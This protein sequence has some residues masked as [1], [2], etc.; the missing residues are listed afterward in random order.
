MADR[1]LELERLHR[2]ARIRRT[3]SL[4][5]HWLARYVVPPRA[6]AI[7]PLP[8]VVPGEVAI[9][10]GGH[11][12]ALIR[13]AGKTVALDPML[14]RWIGGVHRAV[15][16]GLT[17]GHLRDVDV[18]LVSHGHAD[19]LHPA[20]LAHVPASATV[21]GPP[22]TGPRLG[23]RFARL[24]ELAGGRGVAVDGVRVDAV[25]VPHGAGALGPT[26]AFVIAGDGPRVFACA[27]GA[28]GPCYAEVGAALAPDVALLP[29]GGFWPRGFRAR[30]MSPLDALYAFEDLRARVMVPVHHGA[31]PLSYERLGEPARWLK[32]LIDERDLADHVRV[33]APGESA[34]WR[35]AP[36]VARGRD[37]DEPGPPTPPDAIG[38][39]WGRPLPAAMPD[40]RP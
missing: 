23:K 6:V 13:Y 39:G 38:A 25:E 19:H 5:L 33:L 7:E 40:A 3:P 15:A 32:A 12:S 8:E 9:T 30:H 17:P 34:V 18:V 21:I 29:I 22:G 16:P 10:F 35:G 31:F 14:G 36:T 27:D 20:S 4:L 37:P 26:L 24:I 2:R 28:Y 11:A 1:T